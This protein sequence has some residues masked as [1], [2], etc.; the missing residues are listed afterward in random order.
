[1]FSFDPPTALR[2]ISSLLVA[3]LRFGDQ[4]EVA[5]QSAQKKNNTW[6][7][8]S[9]WLS[10][11]SVSHRFYLLW[12]PHSYSTILS[13]STVSHHRFPSHLFCLY[14]SR[15]L[16]LML[17]NPACLEYLFPKSH[18]RN[19]CGAQQNNEASEQLGLS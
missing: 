17:G 7:S 8:W 6:L 10:W 19:Y 1:M 14:Y 2:K 5:P 11:S 4:R 15:N 3:E 16:H 18:V 12:Q 9:V 13:A